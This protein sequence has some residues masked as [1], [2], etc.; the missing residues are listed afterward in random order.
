MIFQNLKYTESVILNIAIKKMRLK[1]R[2]TE[3]QDIIVIYAWRDIESTLKGTQNYTTQHYTTQ[4]HYTRYTTQNKRIYD[5]SVILRCCA[6]TVYY[7]FDHIWVAGLKLMFSFRICFQ[8]SSHKIKRLSQKFL[9]ILRY[10]NIS[11]KMFRTIQLKLCISDNNLN[12]DL[13]ELHTCRMNEHNSRTL[14]QMLCDIKY[15]GTG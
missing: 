10:V 4:L 7:L 5:N 15:A 9:K 13:N 12:D 11:R 1:C 3:I 2:Y 6:P 14:T 8:T